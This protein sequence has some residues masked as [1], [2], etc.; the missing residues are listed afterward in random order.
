MHAV[1]LL[2][3]DGF[4]V[5]AVPCS[6]HSPATSDGS[7]ASLA[8]AGQEA[9]PPLSPEAVQCMD[10]AIASG[11]DGS[12][13]SHLGQL[14]SACCQLLMRS[15]GTALLKVYML[16]PAAPLSLSPLLSKRLC[17]TAPLSGPLTR[18]LA[19]GHAPSS[20]FLTLDQ[21]R[22]LVPLGVDDSGVGGCQRVRGSS[23]AIENGAVCTCLSYM[24][25]C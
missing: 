12:G 7:P 25:I 9:L 8:P 4:N 24:P 17:E 14:L 6:I 2:H 23:G 1:V 18:P 11:L 22:S 20:G 10:A 19:P 15:D 3:A 5:R 16:L 21:A 13:P